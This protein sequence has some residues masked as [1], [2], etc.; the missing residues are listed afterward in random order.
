[1]AISHHE[2]VRS[3]PL[4][5]KLRRVG[6]LERRGEALS[7]VDLM[8]RELGL[9]E[10]VARQRRRVIEW[11]LL[12][13]GHYEHT[14]EE[15]EFGAQI[16][17]RNHA[18]CIGRLHW[19]SLEVRDLRH[20][21]D[22]DE[23]ASHVKAHVDDAQAARGG[24]SIISIFAPR[25]RKQRVAY[26]ESDQILRYAGRLR[27]DGAV[28]GDRQHIDATRGAEALGWRPPGEPSAFDLL[29]FVVRDASGR[30]HIYSIA[31]QDVLE[32]SI[33]HP[34]RDGL[35]ELGLRWYAIPVVS[36]MVLSIGGVEYPCAAFSGHYMST[37]IASRNLVD[38]NRF[39]LLKPVA[40]ALGVFSETDVLWRD[41]ALTELNAAVLDSF[42]T[43]G[44][45]IVD[46]HAASRQFLTFVAQERAKGRCVAADWEW[47]V[48][49]Q[50]S[51]A[52]PVFHLPMK[53]TAT[54][55]NFYRDRAVDGQYLS[56]LGL[57]MPRTRV[58][59]S[60]RR[61]QMRF[62]AWRRAALLR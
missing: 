15:L 52:C 11:D 57:D 14:P 20:I 37:E 42:R 59:A 41:R 28:V 53:A 39:A 34:E 31:D 47:I 56:F 21:T 10:T 33:R 62:H 24:K 27:R 29:P 8:R 16:A 32:V 60:M 58:G 3:D 38:E 17:W 2:F 26:I 23:I 36:G 44:V 1:M 4:D 49:P 6:R 48:P 30:R 18:R 35:T 50:A 9:G 51:A 19:R 5:Q 54:L 25:R 61:L 46:H 55:P 22:A 43:A 12:R 40:R 45:A 7:F 13:H